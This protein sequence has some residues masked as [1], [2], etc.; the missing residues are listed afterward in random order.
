MVLL[1]QNNFGLRGR[2]FKNTVITLLD[3]GTP[4]VKVSAKTA[5]TICPTSPMIVVVVARNGA[6]DAL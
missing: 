2:I 4:V 5:I 1:V 6:S 3:S